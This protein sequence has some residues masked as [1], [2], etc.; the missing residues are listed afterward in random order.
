MFVNEFLQIPTTAASRL[1]SVTCHPWLSCML[2][3]RWCRSAK[4]GATGQPLQPQ[5]RARHQQVS[6]AARVALRRVPVRW[7]ILLALP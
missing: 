1:Q 6:D 3:R 7:Y 4:R 2:W 5:G